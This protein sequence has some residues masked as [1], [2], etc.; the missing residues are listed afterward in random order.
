MQEYPYF[1]PQVLTDPIF[2]QY[3]GQTGTSTTAQ[4]QAAYLLAEEQMTEHLNTFLVPTIVTGT[5]MWNGGNPFELDYGHL[6]IVNRVTIGDINWLNSCE[7]DTATGCAAIRNAQYGYIDVSYMLTCGGCGGVVGYPPYN[8]HVVYQSGFSSGTVT[9]PSILAALSIAA[10]INLNEWDVSLSNEGVADIGVQSFSNQSYSENRVKLGHTAFGSS[11]M[12][13][14][15]ARLV[16]KYRSRP[17][18]SLHR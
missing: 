9:Q 6:Q 14:R 12:A 4:R 17:G 10:Q 5:Y 2:L 18:L 1:T 13:Q 7:V 3:G 8:I 15:A 16:N 11:A